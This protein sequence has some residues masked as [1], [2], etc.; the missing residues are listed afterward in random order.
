MVRSSPALNERIG[1]GVM[2]GKNEVDV[3]STTTKGVAPV[4]TEGKEIVLPETVMAVPP[5]AR[6][7]VPMTNA[8]EVAVTGDP[9]I[10]MTAG[11]EIINV[12]E[13]MTITEVP[14][15]KVCPPTGTADADETGGSGSGSGVAVTGEEK[16]ENEVEPVLGLEP[17]EADSGDESGD[18]SG[19]GLLGEVDSG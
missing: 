9:P 19:A 4:L 5:G 12:C 15:V 6:V 16:T 18:D 2:T 10:V 14:S 8:D 11:V 3:P 7:C 17:L 1:A 13:G